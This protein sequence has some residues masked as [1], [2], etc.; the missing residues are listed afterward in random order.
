MNVNEKNSFREKEEIMA[1][2]FYEEFNS[3]RQMF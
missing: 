1:E 2:L 3:Q